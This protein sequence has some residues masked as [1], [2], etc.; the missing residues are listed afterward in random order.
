MSSY[1]FKTF[2]VCALLTLFAING[3]AASYKFGVTPWQKGQTN[4]DIN[5]FYRPMMDYLSKKTGDEFII[6]ST[7]DYQQMIEYLAAGKVDFASISPVPYVLAKKKNPAIQLIVTEL[8]W[9]KREEN[10]T[11]SYLGFI[12]TLKSNTELNTL[13]DLKN[14]RFGFVKKESSSGFKYPNALLIEHGINY[15]DYFKKHYFLG[16][17]PRVTDAIVQG[18]IDAGATW[19]F[20]LKQAIAKHGDIFKIITTT[21]PIPN[22]CI[23]AHSAIPRKKAHKIQSLLTQIDPVI[24][25]GLPAS[26]YTVKPDSFYDI[27]RKVIFE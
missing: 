13:S 10:L 19:D 5:R 9:D 3:F 23:A 11:D 17:H 4:D 6:V 8:S 7:K 2:F 1:F 14:K 25:Q 24:L 15:I 27:V 21:P 18:S 22:L 16:S 12:V 26:G 20:N